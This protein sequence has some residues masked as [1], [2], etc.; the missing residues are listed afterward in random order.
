MIPSNQLDRLDSE[1]EQNQYG[2]W[3]ALIICI[4]L[5]VVFWG[6]VFYAFFG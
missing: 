3:R 6:G 5:S 2:L 1:Y 4:P